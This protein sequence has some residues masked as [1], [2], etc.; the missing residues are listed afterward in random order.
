MGRQQPWSPELE[1]M[2]SR[3]DFGTDV[4]GKRGQDPT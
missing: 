4:K 2:C 1:L 3:A